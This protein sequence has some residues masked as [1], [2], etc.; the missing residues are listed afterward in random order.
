MEREELEPS[1]LALKSGVPRLKGEQGRSEMAGLRTGFDGNLTENFGGIGDKRKSRSTLSSRLRS[2]ALGKIM[3]DAGDLGSRA[4][5][6]S[7]RLDRS[8]GRL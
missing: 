4:R 5:A 7:R 8:I 1:Q 6:R 2:D 3:E